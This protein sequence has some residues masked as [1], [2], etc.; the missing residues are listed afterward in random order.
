M[1]L[2]ALAMTICGVLVTVAFM[3][4]RPLIPIRLETWL[5]IGYGLLILIPVWGCIG[6]ASVN[7]GYKVSSPHQCRK[8]TLP[9][10]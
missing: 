6:F 8:S 10:G 2:Y 1:S 5:L 7:F 4:A 3:V 9:V